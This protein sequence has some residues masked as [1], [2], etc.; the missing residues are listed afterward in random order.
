MVESEY[1]EFDN[2]V[3]F[4]SNGV[5][6]AFKR[7]NISED[8]LK[9]IVGILNANNININ[10]ILINKDN[11]IFTEYNGNN[12]ILMKI[13]NPNQLDKF[14]IFSPI[15]N[16]K[17][18]NIPLVWEKKIDNYMHQ[19]AEYGLNRELLLNTFNYYIGLAENAISIYNRC[20]KSNIRYVV[21]HRRLNYP[22]TYPV[23]LDPTNLLVDTISR[24]ISE[25]IKTKF[26][27]DEIS[28]K[29]VRKI[30]SK[31]HLNNNEMNILLARLL[32]PSY[33]FDIFDSII[34]TNN[35]KELETI[36]KKIIPY[37]EFLKQF[38]NE[39]GDYQLFIV[40]WIKK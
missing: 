35:D 5:T 8:Y 18:D 33:Y 40:D 32:Y 12:Y 21:S 1:Y 37:E 34:Q 7:I 27:K 24:D 36:I 2:Y 30:V 26:F 25:Y 10:K 6:Y 17:N 23:F 28:I 16:N 14:E 29:D 15:L 20:D 22:L 11:K 13:I 3:I 39:F 19:I 38:Y 9:D 4:V 31:Y